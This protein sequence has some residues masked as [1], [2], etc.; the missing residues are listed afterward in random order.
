LRSEIIIDAGADGT[1]VAF[2]EDGD[3]VEIYIE[4]S[5]HR[6]ILGN[7]YLGRIENV[8]Q[9]MQAAFVDI[10]CDKNAFLYIDDI[11]SRGQEKDIANLVDVGQDIAVQVI[12]E[13]MGTKGPRVTTNIKLPGRYVILLPYM[14]YIGISKKIEN[15]AEKQRLKDLAQCIKPD[16]MGI[17]IRTEAQGK[18]KGELA[19]DLEF[20]IK[21]W[22]KVKD[23]M[24][25]VNA[26]AILHKDDDLIA[27]LV[28]D[29]FTCGIDKLVI[30]SK[31]KYN[32][33][34]ELL[35]AISP[36]LNDKVEYYNGDKRIYE[37]YKIEEKLLK[38]VER[39]VWLKNGGYIIIDETEALT[40]IDV[41]TG[42]YVG[43]DNPR[44]TILLT[45]KEAAKEIAKQ[46][47]LRDIGG[48]IIID[49]ID[50]A[51]NMQQE[52]VLEEL[53]KHL[54]RDRSRTTVMGITHL[55]LVEMTRKKLRDNLS[56]I[57]MKKCPYC[58]G[59]GKVLLK[60]IMGK[61]VDNTNVIC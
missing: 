8:L 56:S 15:E 38:A 4:D 51:N 35:D 50:M 60:E 9:G 22:E 24:N 28:R 17:I 47:R 40:V 1:R 46:L 42:K 6:S 20:L 33:V 32:Q 3:L 26:P 2:L 29:G 10:G 43:K 41:N 44:E 48:I 34:L 54:K 12:K 27:R 57:L 16:G 23:R 14:N 5:G 58:R 49:F 36:S 11:I 25:K 21:Q 30:N 18:E 37:Y 19:R 39:K 59:T 45:N 61:D 7:I 31:E 13:P 53:K 55:G 52:E